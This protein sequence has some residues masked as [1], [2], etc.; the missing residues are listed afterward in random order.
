ML[1]NEV[2]SE[3]FFWTSSEFF[4]KLSQPFSLALRVFSFFLNRLFIHACI[5]L[6]IP[7]YIYNHPIFETIRDFM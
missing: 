4:F 2:L 5:N 6:Y 3:I 7:T 1:Q